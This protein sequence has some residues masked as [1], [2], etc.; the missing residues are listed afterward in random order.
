M[1][2]NINLTKDGGETI[3]QVYSFLLKNN[4]IPQQLNTPNNNI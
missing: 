3:K 2:S 4:F 1:Q